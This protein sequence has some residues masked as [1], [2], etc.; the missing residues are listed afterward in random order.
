M[1]FMD[2]MNDPLHA[3]ASLAL[4]RQVTV[5]SAASARNRGGEE[6]GRSNH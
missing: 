4:I 3:Y 6:A 5:K 2:S 1:V